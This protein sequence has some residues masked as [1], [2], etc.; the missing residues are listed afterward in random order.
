[1]KLVPFGKSAGVD[2]VEARYNIAG[3]NSTPGYSSSSISLDSSTAAAGD[4][5]RKCN[6]T[7]PIFVYKSP[8]KVE[9]LAL[10]PNGHYLAVATAEAVQVVDL[11]HV[12]KGGTV[13]PTATFPA[14][15]VGG[16]TGTLSFSPDGH[17]LLVTM[18]S[19]KRVF[20]IPSGA[21]SIHIPEVCPGL[22][23]DVSFHS[24]GFLPASA[25]LWVLGKIHL[26]LALRDKTL[27]AFV[28]MIYWNRTP[29]PPGTAV[30]V[31]LSPDTPFL[32]PKSLPPPPVQ[33]PQPYDGVS[34]H[35]VLQGTVDNKYQGEKELRALT[36]VLDYRSGLSLKR[37]LT[38]PATRVPWQYMAAI[39]PQL[40]LLIVISS[41]TKTM[42]TDIKAWD[43][44]GSG[45]HSQE[46]VYERVLEHLERVSFS[47]NKTLHVS[48]DGNTLWYH[49]HEG[50]AFVETRTG[51]AIRLV[52]LP[53]QNGVWESAAVSEDMTRVLFAGKVLGFTYVA[54]VAAVQRIA[55]PD[56]QYGVRDA[57]FLPGQSLC[58]ALH[59]D[60]NHAVSLCDYLNGT[61]LQK[62]SLWDKPP[63][64]LR[65]LS[66]DRRCV[67]P[68]RL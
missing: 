20:H 6:K 36:F 58:L 63:R 50:V 21:E 65:L 29:F 56:C 32:T 68:L 26:H 24:G 52:N 64:N 10:S 49:T 33:V 22:E 38:L 42:S 16:G 17:K 3:N 41:D 37:T 34:A 27:P 18:R 55:F 30:V 1:M 31:S 62:F 39:V 57:A 23:E 60:D 35:L 48:G 4:G 8:K 51:R 13:A 12:L 2:D 28:Q 47:S 66:G 54:N 45:G 61:R 5:G 53:G 44:G 43:L 11:S 15:I 67:C 59:R 7:T 40:S 25:G 19:G 46:P 14:V 9:R